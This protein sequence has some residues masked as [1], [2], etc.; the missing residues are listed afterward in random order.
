MCR[1]YRDVTPILIVYMNTN[2]K[3]RLDLAENTFHL[4]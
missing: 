1:C 2:G 4:V 3:L